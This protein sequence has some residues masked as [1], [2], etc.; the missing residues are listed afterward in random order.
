MSVLS[1]SWEKG[2][3]QEFRRVEAEAQITLTWAFCPRA[4]NSG[5]KYSSAG[6]LGTLCFPFLLEKPG[7]PPCLLVLSPLNSQNA[8][9][10][11]DVSLPTGPY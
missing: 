7:C 4:R 11:G 8:R 6:I 9:S 2:T 10:I 3:E 1:W 5:E